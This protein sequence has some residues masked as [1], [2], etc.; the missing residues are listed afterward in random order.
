MGRSIKKII[1]NPNSPVVVVGVFIVGINIPKKRHIIVATNKHGQRVCARVRFRASVTFMIKKKPRIEQAE[2]IGKRKRKN[3]ICSGWE[4]KEDRS[5][6]MCDG[7]CARVRVDT[8]SLN[9]PHTTHL[10][11][12]S[13]ET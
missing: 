8:A 12:E 4:C 13:I 3:D 1:H 10:D 5:V 6:N 7:T 9:D 11:H 2:W